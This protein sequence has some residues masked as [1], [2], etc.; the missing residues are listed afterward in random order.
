MIKHRYVP[1]ALGKKKYAGK[2]GGG[3]R[4]KG[5]DAAPVNPGRPVTY[6]TIAEPR[7]TGS[8]TR[9]GDVVVRYRL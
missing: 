2:P 6:T 5:D 9:G 3:A 4:K 8:N 7:F 1:F